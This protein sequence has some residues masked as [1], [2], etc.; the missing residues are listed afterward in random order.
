MQVT[1]PAL[2]TQPALAEL[3]V[4]SAGSTSLTVKPPTL[5]DGPPLCTVSV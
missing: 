2:F 5:F 4:A 1:V 3:K